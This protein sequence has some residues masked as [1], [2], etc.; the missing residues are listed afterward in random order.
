MR[1]ISAGKA[2]PETVQRSEA[3]IKPSYVFLAELQSWIP[4][5]F[6]EVDL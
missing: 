3:G 6:L 5:S 4:Q 1:G 2:C